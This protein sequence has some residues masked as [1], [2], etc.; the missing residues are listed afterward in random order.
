MAGQ[1]TKAFDDGNFDTD[2]LG[3]SQPVLV[4]FWAEWCGPCQLLGPI[5]DEIANDYAGRL[6]VGKVDIDKAVR[7]SSS[8]GV[9]S[10]PTVILFKDGQ[11]VDRIVGARAKRD[12]VKAIH[13][14][15]GIGAAAAAG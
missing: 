6:V 14:K 7:V 13:E 8:L 5:I 10:I 15:L 2:V 4:D 12:Y 9:Q 1:N 11:P 3:N